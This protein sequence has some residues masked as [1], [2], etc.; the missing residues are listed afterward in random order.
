M[1]SKRSWLWNVKAIGKNKWHH[2]IFY[3]KNIYLD[4]QIVMLSALVWKLW[5]KTSFCIMMAYVTPSRTSHIQTD[6]WFI[7]KPRPKLFCV[8]IWWQFVQQES[9]HGPK[10]NFTGLW[11]WKVKVFLLRLILRRQNFEFNVGKSFLYEFLHIL[12]GFTDQIRYAFMYVTWCGPYAMDCT[13]PRHVCI[14]F[15]G[16]SPW[17][18]WRSYLLK[19]EQSIKGVCTFLDVMICYHIVPLYVSLFVIFDLG[20]Y[21]FH[22]AYHF[23]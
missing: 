2:H 11:S 13:L 15:S 18:V 16:I 19:V 1:I 9:R 10:C 5:S 23:T 7:E 17:V 6:F 21:L 12:N 3:I 8:K 22:I 14:H 4:A 20:Y